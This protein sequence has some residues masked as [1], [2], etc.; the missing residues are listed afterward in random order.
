MIIY[1]YKAVNLSSIAL[2]VSCVSCKHDQQR[3]LIY[4]NFFTLFYLSIFPLNK[5]AFFRCPQC[6]EETKKKKFLKNLA[7]EGNDAETAK[8]HL[9]QLIK[10]TKTPL[11]AF[12]F[13]ILILLFIGIIFALNA[14]HDHQESQRIESYFTAP[15]NQALFIIKIN[16]TK[17]PYHIAYIPETFEQDYVMLEWKY[18][19]QFASEA[20]KELVE[21]RTALYDGKI[22]DHF[23]PP[24]LITKESLDVFSIIKIEILNDPVDWQSVHWDET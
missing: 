1:G 10:Q 23:N 15:T 5:N 18:G 4:R 3:L 22:K 11:K 6:G 13:P 14:Y 7:N 24:F 2:P 20:R 17:Y 9:N 12:V 8:N 16:E 21:A 19:Y